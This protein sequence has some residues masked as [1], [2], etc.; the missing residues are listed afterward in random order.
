[1]RRALRRRDLPQQEVLVPPHLRVLSGLRSFSN[2]S[3]RVSCANEVG[4]SPFTP[5]LHFQTPE[6]GER[7][8]QQQ[9]TDN[10]DVKILV[11]TVAFLKVL[12]HV[13]QSNQLLSLH[14]KHYFTRPP[15]DKHVCKRVCR[16]NKDRS[17]CL[18]VPVFSQLQQALRA[19]LLFVVCG[20]QLE[21]IQ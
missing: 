17:C 8:S 9:V 1:M 6:S 12:L 18:L 3:V 7:R 14:R 10:S 19:R 20:V 4:A 21:V 15:A 13:K 11:I 16:I 2:Y 5:W